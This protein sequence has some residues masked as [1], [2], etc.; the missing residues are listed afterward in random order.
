M[1]WDPSFSFKEE[2]EEKASPSL[3]DALEKDAINLCVIGLFDHYLLLH[4][5]FLPKEERSGFCLVN[6]KGAKARLTYE[7]LITGASFSLQKLLL[8]FIL[9]F[10]KGESDLLRCHLK[11]L[12]ANGIGIRPFG[13]QTFIVESLLFPEEERETKERIEIFLESVKS[14]SSY[15]SKKEEVAKKLACYE[16]KQKRGWTL[17]EAKI[18]VEALLKSKS[19]YFSPSGEKTMVHFSSEKLKLF[20][21]KKM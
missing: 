6:L 5:S 7:K 9:E 11:D 20:F 18:L 19:P 17:V 8:P 14:G 2:K 13:N 10:S 16:S 4:P 21:Q 15:Q 3:F 1:R 12:A